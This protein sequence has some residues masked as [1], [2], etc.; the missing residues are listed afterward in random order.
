MDPIRVPPRAKLEWAAV[1]HGARLSNHLLTHVGEPAPKSNFAKVNDLYPFESLAAF[2]KGYLDAALEHLL[3]WADYAAP[4]KFHPE[5]QVTF[6]LR[7]AYTLARAAIEAASPAVWLM[8]ATG[9]RECL[10]RYFSLVR[11]DLQMHAKS[12]PSPERRADAEKKEMELLDRIRGEFSPKDVAPPGGYEATVKLA[13]EEPGVGLDPT[14]TSW[15]W[16]AAS[17]SAHG[18]PWASKDLQVWVQQDHGLVEGNLIRVP[19]TDRMAEALRAASTMT[20][21][22]CLRFAD[23]SGADLNALTENARVWL[24]RVVPFKEDADLEVIS[25]LRERQDPCGA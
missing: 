10:R 19:D 18:M 15:I 13:C 8:N 16:R 4:L 2:T 6:G 11:W 9:P 14:E 22:G 23:F 21:Y 7:P 12:T 20:S 25:R 17:G 24:A 1:A 5:H 3:L